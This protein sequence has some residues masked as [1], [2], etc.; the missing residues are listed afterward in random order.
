MS[1]DFEIENKSVFDGDNKEEYIKSKTLKFTCKQ[2]D[3]LKKKF[4]SQEKIESFSEYIR[5][6]IFKGLDVVKNG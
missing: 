1:F 5:Y 3:I 6:L 4:R 2:L